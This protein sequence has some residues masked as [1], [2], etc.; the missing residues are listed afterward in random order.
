MTGQ[1]RALGLVALGG[2]LL[3][4]WTRSRPLTAT[5]TTSEGYDLSPYGGPTSYPLEIRQ[6]AV[7]I[8]KQEG[9]YVAGSVPQRSNNPGDLKI[10]GKPTLPGTSI[11]MF[12]SA[13][14]GWAAL[15]RQLYLILTS[16]SAYYN[17]DM[18][19]DQMARVWTATEQDA[20]SRNVS[21]FLG[22][23]PNTKLWEVLA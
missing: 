6:M 17:L 13:D 16:Q 4:W 2:G 12:A 8:A 19:I 21:S 10:P 7:A 23:S 18:T 15:H 9:F 1:E 5:V 14:L 11:T 22:V 20:W 3:F